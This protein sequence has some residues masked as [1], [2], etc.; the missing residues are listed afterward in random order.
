MNAPC[1][2]AECNLYQNVDFPEHDL[3]VGE[4]QGAYAKDGELTDGLVDIS[5]LRPLLFD[6]AGKK[7]RSLGTER[8]ACWN[9]VKQLK[10]KE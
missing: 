5:K 3:L 10:G 7:Y 2:W 1:A 9:V 6:M 8:R 4:I